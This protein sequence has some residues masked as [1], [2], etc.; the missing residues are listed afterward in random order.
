MANL[1]IEKQ[2]KIEELISESSSIY[3]SGDLLKSIQLLSEAWEELPQNKFDFDDSY[4]ISRYI[5]NLSLEMKDFDTAKKWILLYEKSDLERPDIGE[6]EF[7]KG[8]VAYESGDILNALELFKIADKKSEGR[9]FEG[10]NLKYHNFLKN[11][12]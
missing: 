3:N 8:K 12:F 6:R 7:L 10:E 9:C 2:N 5:I 11:K 4:H 1:N